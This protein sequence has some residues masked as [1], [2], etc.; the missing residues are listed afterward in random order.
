[1]TTVPS[2][3]GPYAIEREIGRGGMGV[4]YLGR[5]SK[6]DRAVAI[7]A[8]PEHLAEDAE[9]LSRFEREAKTLAQLSHANVAGIY[10]VEE[11]DGAWC[12]DGR[13]AGPNVELDDFGLFLWAYG[14][15]AERW[16][17]DPWIAETLPAVLEGVADPL[18]LDDAPLVHQQGAEVLDRVAHAQARAHALEHRLPLA[19]RVER[20]EDG[21][22]QLVVA[23][24]QVGELLE[25]PSHVGEVALLLRQREQRAGVA[26]GGS[27]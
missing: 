2:Q 1:M 19:A 22:S 26:P 25:L 4:V 15:Y 27:G 16:P 13:D 5:D 21:V 10:G 24:E 23:R 11:S 20:A 9:R 17:D 3:L 7:K 8:M 6:L 12:P 18:E 14:E